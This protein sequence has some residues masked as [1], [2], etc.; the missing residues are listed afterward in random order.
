MVWKRSDK[1]IGAS[2]STNLKNSN[3]PM[4]RRIPTE[5]QST[6]SEKFKKWI[7]I[8]EERHIEEVVD[9]DDTLE[10]YLHCNPE[11]FDAW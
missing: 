7:G 5:E 4:I 11:I 6:E 1:F 10:K 3:Y 8:I 2:E 9:E